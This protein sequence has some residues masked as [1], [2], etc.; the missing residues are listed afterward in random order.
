MPFIP[1]EISVG[2]KRG[3]FVAIRESDN[4]FRK[5]IAK[6]YRRHGQHRPGIN[7]LFIKLVCKRKPAKK[8]PIRSVTKL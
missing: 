3:R 8:H 7:W 4:V 1:L 2:T 6:K 5:P